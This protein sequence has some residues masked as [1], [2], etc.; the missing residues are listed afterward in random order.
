MNEQPTREQRFVEKG[1]TSD[2]QTVA[3]RVPQGSILGPVLF[4]S[5]INGFERII[6]KSAEDTNPGGA[7]HSLKGRET[8]QRGLYKLEGWTITNRT[9][10]NKGKY[11][12]LHLGWAT[13]DESQT[14]E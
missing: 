6:S 8:L 9:R 7:V 5:F 4:N 1:L 3:N 10:F 2:W 12:I 14:G 13:L 11:Q